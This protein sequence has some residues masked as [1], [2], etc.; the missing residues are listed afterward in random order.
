MTKLHP[1][2]E[3]DLEEWRLGWRSQTAEIPVVSLGLKASNKGDVRKKSGKFGIAICSMTDL[4]DGTWRVLAEATMRSIAEM[5]KSDDVTFIRP[6][7]DAGPDLEDSRKFVNTPNRPGQA[8]ISGEYTGKNVIIGVIDSGFNIFHDSL[9]RKNGKTRIIALWIIE[10]SGKATKAEQKY[11]KPAP[12]PYSYGSYY[13]QKTIDWLMKPLPPKTKVSIKH[14]QKM[15]RNDLCRHIRRY[16][17]HGT[18]V[19]GI[20][21]GNGIHREGNPPVKSFRQD[22]GIAPDAEF[23]LVACPKSDHVLADAVGL[24]D[25]VAETQTGKRPSAINISM[26]RNDGPHT[27]AWPSAKELKVASKNSRFVTV[28]SIGNAGSSKLHAAGLLKKGESATVEFE[29]DYY[30]WGGKKYDE[31]VRAEIWTGYRD[32]GSVSFDIETPEGKKV[33]NIEVGGELIRRRGRHP[34]GVKAFASPFDARFACLWLYLQ[35]SHLLPNGNY[36]PWKFTINRTDDGPGDLGWHFFP[37]KYVIKKWKIFEVITPTP[38]PR[39]TYGAT[40]LG[41]DISVGSVELDKT[42]SSYSSR[43][44]L[45]EHFSTPP[46][47]APALP[48]MTAPGSQIMAPI[49][50]MDEEPQVGHAN[51][52]GGA[53]WDRY[54]DLKGTSMATPHISGAIA[55]I[56]EKKPSITKEEILAVLK[57]SAASDG[58]PDKY[59]LGWGWLDIKKAISLL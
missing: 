47:T 45:A 3:F 37:S 20:A 2:L 34:F 49:T 36:P 46:N 9:R 23:I 18:H 11:R 4:E 8:P 24:I 38:T 31:G 32:A 14:R 53:Y 19:A 16:A 56:R 29:I 52:S 10:P 48:S 26:S 21:G 22:T 13:D 35:R 57:A 59:E 41:S 6:P 17:R 54:A 43:G 50:M 33:S 39:A 25:L 28:G 55:L 40:S 27:E 30:L 44:P 51:I 5:A 15:M 12:D 58:I 7:R 42:V 1:D